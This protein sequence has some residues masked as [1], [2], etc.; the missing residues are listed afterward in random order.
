MVTQ[1][2]DRRTFPTGRVGGTHDERRRREKLLTSQSN[3][4]RLKRLEH[5]VWGMPDGLYDVRPG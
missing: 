4:E 2:K 5:S 3:S 1:R